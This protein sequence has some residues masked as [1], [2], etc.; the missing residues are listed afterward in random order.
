[1]SDVLAS[2]QD[3][4]MRDAATCGRLAMGAEGAGRRI[5]LG[6]AAIGLAWCGITM[7]PDTLRLPRLRRHR[8]DEDASPCRGTSDIA[9]LA[10]RMEAEASLCERLRE[11]DPAFGRLARE[12]R[13]G[14]A[15]C[16]QNTT[17]SSLAAGS[18]LPA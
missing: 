9:G 4:A 16:S 8:N 15:A 5:E 11:S 18:A 14:A 2:M 1:M 7:S 3:R 12:L 10:A 6:R 13:R 17:A